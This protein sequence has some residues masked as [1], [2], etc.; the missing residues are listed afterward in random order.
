MGLRSG[1][2]LHFFRAD[3]AAFVRIRA[4]DEP[5]DAGGILHGGDQCIGLRRRVILAG[6]FGVIGHQ[7]K[8]LLQRQARAFTQLFPAHF[9]Q[10]AD[11]FIPQPAHAQHTPGLFA[12]AHKALCAFHAAGKMQRC[13]FGDAMPVIFIGSAQGYIAARDMRNGDMPCRSGHSHRKNFKA[14]AQKQQCIGRILCKA[15]I[16]HLHR[17]RNG[18]GHGLGAGFGQ[19][20]QPCCNGNAVGLDLA[21]G[22]AVGFAQMRA[23]DQQL[24]LHLRVSIQRLQNAAQ[25]P[26]FSA[27]TGDHRNGVLHG[28]SAPLS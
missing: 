28:R 15:G 25:Q 13:H 18:F 10:L 14:V 20:G 23:G 16:K 22:L 17:A 6:S 12:H 4:R 2:R 21:H 19:N 8:R 3:P 11:I 24:Q 9:G 26:V 7:P 1:K 5:I 27:C